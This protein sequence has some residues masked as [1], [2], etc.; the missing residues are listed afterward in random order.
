MQHIVRT[1]SRVATLAVLLV[2]WFTNS[3][4]LGIHKAHANDVHY[5]AHDDLSISE[6]DLLSDSEKSDIQRSYQKIAE[7]NSLLEVPSFTFV[8]LVT[9]N[10]EESDPVELVTL[11]PTPTHSIQ[12]AST[13]ID[14]KQ[15]RVSNA[16]STEIKADIEVPTSTVPADIQV[17]IETYAPQYGADPA[18]MAAIAKC[19]SGFN[20][21]AVSP[22]GAYVG[23]FQ[24]VS[25]T[26]V[27]NRNAMGLD[28]NPS[29]RANA[30]EAIKTAAFKMGRDGYGAWPVC[31]KI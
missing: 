15:I 20:P 24:F 28:P 19:E 22:S 13:T 12:I 6:Y 21:G 4:Y 9:A 2:V 30:E 3:P 14:V 7:S 17:L 25:G 31:G 18:K 11:T 1:L 23:L 16:A 8:P 5:S 10:V 27:S 29:L 26:W